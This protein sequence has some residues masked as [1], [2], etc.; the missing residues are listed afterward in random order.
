M[1]PTESDAASIASLPSN[2]S[3]Y[4][5]PYLQDYVVIDDDLANSNRLSSTSSYQDDNGNTPVRITSFLSSS[6]A[7]RLS[8][9]PNVETRQTSSNFTSLSEIVPLKYIHVHCTILT[10]IGILQ[11]T[12]QVAIVAQEDYNPDDY[13]G[14]VW[15]GIYLLFVAISTLSICKY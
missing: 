7:T 13:A 11:I 5:N 10:I 1:S 14:G 9:M 12:L 2:Y 4:D 15:S 8:A 3:L 6:A